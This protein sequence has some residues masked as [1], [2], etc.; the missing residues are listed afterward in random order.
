MNPSTQPGASGYSR[1]QITLHWLSVALMTSLVLA[2]ELRH[3]L[4]DHMA[5][6]MRSIMILHIGSGMAL[7]VVMLMRSALRALRPRA[8]VGHSLQQW[9]AHVVHLAMY[10]F[11]LGECMVG[12]TIVN[13]KGLTVPM[14]GLGWHFPRLVEAD[15]Q[16]VRY[17]VQIHDWLGLLLYALLAAHIGAA[18]WHHWVVKDD[19]L[20]HMGRRGWRRA[21]RGQALASAPQNA[22]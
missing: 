13:A 18:L 22:A 19:T 11:V 1:A 7:L 20:S 4:V 8:A 21:R 12:W 9:C 16:L 5:L 17:A 2:G 6:S 10:A 14:P 3:L 15:P